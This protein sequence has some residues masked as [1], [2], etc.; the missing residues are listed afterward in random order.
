MPL[1]KNNN[2]GQVKNIHKPKLDRVFEFAIIITINPTAF[3]V[4]RDGSFYF[5]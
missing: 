5:L 3:S 4:Y 2:L 1:D